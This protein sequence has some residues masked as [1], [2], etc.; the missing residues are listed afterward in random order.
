MIAPSIFIAATTVEVISNTFGLSNETFPYDKILVN[1]WYSTFIRN[2]LPQPAFP[3]KKICK[4]TR[5]W[6]SDIDL[7]FI[8]FFA[9]L[10]T[11]SKSSRCFRLSN[12]ILELISLSGIKTGKMVYLI[13]N[14]LA[15]R[16][17]L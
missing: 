16:Y 9:R 2:D 17:H 10:C 11:M 7:I 1:D 3:V 12:L 15:R 4:G 14:Q 8:D 5:G 6:A 13:M